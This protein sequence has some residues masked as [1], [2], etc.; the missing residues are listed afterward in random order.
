MCLTAK[1]ITAIAFDKKKQALLLV[2]EQ[3]LDPKHEFEVYQFSLKKYL[4][5][6]VNKKPKYVEMT[7]E[8]VSE[9][10]ARLDVFTKPISV[11]THED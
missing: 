3:I 1:G 7:I 6:Y 8:D 9:V 2:R 5:P 4:D 11:F 10:I